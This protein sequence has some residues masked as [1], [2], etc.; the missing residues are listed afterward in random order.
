MSGSVKYPLSIACIFIWIGFVC[1]I[2]FMEAWLK[3]KAPGITLPLG[4]GIGRLV[5]MAL[6]KVELAFAT[7]TAFVAFTTTNQ[8]TKKAKIS[9]TAAILIVLFQTFWLLPALDER[10][11]QII[12]KQSVPPSAHHIWYVGLEIVKVACLAATGI[13][14]LRRRY[15][16]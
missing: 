6:N 1:A 8:F 10:A 12:N 11:F 15:S 5:F 9:L 14:L 16:K 3:F 4:L 7:I 13:S 2:S